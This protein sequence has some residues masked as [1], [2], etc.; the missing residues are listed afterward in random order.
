[1]FA[2]LLLAAV[3]VQPPA[4]E[5]PPFGGVVSAGDFVRIASRDGVTT[6]RVLTAREAERVQ[7]E[8]ARYR[9]DALNKATELAAELG[10]ELPEDASSDELLDLLNEATRGSR[11]RNPSEIFEPLRDENGQIDR[12]AM[13]RQ[14]RLRTELRGAV[15]N[16]SV[17]P[18][19]LYG[20]PRRVMAVSDRW[21]TI[22]SGGDVSHLAGA[23]IRTITE[24]VARY[25]ERTGTAMQEQATDKS[26]TE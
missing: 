19:S 18:R 1:M 4:A 11:E 15:Q 23:H 16:A 7:A 14:S 26:D 17:G 21:I 9:Q 10:L 22:R 8:D 2:P 3:C 12:E 6:L 25:A 24:S 13:Q 20:P 5:P